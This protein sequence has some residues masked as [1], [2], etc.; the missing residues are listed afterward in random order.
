MRQTMLPSKGISAKCT[1]K[2]SASDE[3]IQRSQKRA[4]VDGDRYASYE[5]WD[6]ST[7]NHSE[8]Q[9]KA[10]VVTKPKFPGLKPRSD[11]TTPP[12][13]CR[14]LELPGELLNMVYKI[15]LDS[16]GMIVLRDGPTQPFT[17]EQLGEIRGLVGLGGACK[18]TRAEYF[19]A[20][21]QKMNKYATPGTFQAY[22]RCWRQTRNIARDLTI[23]IANLSSFHWHTMELYPLLEACRKGTHGKISIVSGPSTYESAKAAEEAVIANG[24]NLASAEDE[25][26]IRVQEFLDATTQKPSRGTAHD[27]KK[28]YDYFGKSVVQLDMRLYTTSA[29]VPK[30]SAFRVKLRGSCTPGWMILGTKSAR[31][32]K[33]WE[34]V[35]GLGVLKEGWDKVS[36]D[37]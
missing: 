1:R 31:E 6:G 35:T 12:P 20:F 16:P 25:R 30:D 33:Q 27:V 32:K 13:R 34:Y 23:D 36:V 18:R 24:Q 3:D 10:A 29:S 5:E 14:L 28:W 9:Y 2:R 22:I 37:A 4:R 15:L 11:E 7:T 21:Q 19:S 8:A 26:I 17:P